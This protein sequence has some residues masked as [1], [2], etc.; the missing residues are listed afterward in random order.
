MTLKPK[1]QLRQVMPLEESSI[2]N[3]ARYRCRSIPAAGALNRQRSE[4]AVCVFV[5]C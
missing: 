5:L 4:F 1:Y 2:T 3:L